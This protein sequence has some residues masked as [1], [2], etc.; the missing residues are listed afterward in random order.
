[1]ENFYIP[2]DAQ[3]CSEM[4]DPICPAVTCCPACKNELIALYKCIILESDYTALDYL[5][6]TCP[7][8]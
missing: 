5:A 8:G 4:E 1:M 2:A 3:T 7:M 6:E